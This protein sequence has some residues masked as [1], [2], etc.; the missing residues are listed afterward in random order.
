MMA[1]VIT[2]DGPSGSGKGTLAGIIAERLGWHLLDSG[3]L[4]RIVGW[5]AQQRGLA[6]D[7]GPQL[8]A[9]AAGLDIR[10]EA[11]GV[12]VDG[13]AAERDIRTEEAGKAASAVAVL[14]AVRDALFAVQLAMRK[15]PGLVADG[16]DMGTVVFIDAQLKIF[17]EASAEIRAERRLRQLHPHGAAAGLRARLAS[18]RDSIIERDARDKT[19]VVSPLVPAAD[20]I[21]LDSTRMT[22][23]QVVA[24][25]LRLADARGLRGSS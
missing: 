10:F 19:R 15:P 13:V 3:A 8:A 17:L 5:V 6:L 2:V 21:V 12:W 20:A 11:D 23:H 1:P 24:E 22:I 18:I 9:M 25:A 7:D 16:R 14:P 4:Y